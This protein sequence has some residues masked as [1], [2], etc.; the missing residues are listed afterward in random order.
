MTLI[1]VTAVSLT[2]K[3][4]D[5]YG[6]RSSD[7]SKNKRFLQGATKDL[8]VVKIHNQVRVEDEE[9]EMNVS[10]KHSRR[11]FFRQRQ[12]CQKL[13]ISSDMVLSKF[14]PDLIGVYENIQ[15]VEK[16]IFK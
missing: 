10:T 11:K 14:Y 6:N 3:V 4:I 16:P 1:S 5:K 12:C 2:V 7:N 13:K 15:N 8:N 9:L